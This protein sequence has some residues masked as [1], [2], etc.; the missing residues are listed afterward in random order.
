MKLKGG[1]DSNNM[2]SCCNENSKQIKKLIAINVPISKCN[3]RCH[4]CYLTQLNAWDKDEPKLEYSP[5]FIGKAFSKKRLGGTCLIN[6]TG[7]GETL[8]LPEMPEIIRVLLE[9][10]HFLEVVTNGLLTQRFEELAK[11]PEELLNRLELKCSFHYLELKKRNLMDVFFD[12]IAMIKSA[13]ASVTIEL[14]P[15]DEIIDEIEDIKRVCLERMGALCHLT[16]GR[17][18]TNARDV[19]TKLPLDEYKKTWSQFDSEMFNFK[20][21]VLNVKRKEFCYAGLWTLYVNLFTG[22]ARQCYGCRSNQ[23]IYKNIE[24]PIVFRPVGK[25]CKQP[26]C[27][28][29]HAFLTLGVIPELDTPS[30]LD[31]R[32]RID[33]SGKHWFSDA[34]IVAFSTRLSE[35]N[36][37]YTSVEKIKYYISAPIHGMRIIFANLKKGVAVICKR[38]RK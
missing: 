1:K 20:M 17:D 3:L 4:Y 24:K 15:N 8:I 10:G 38:R 19:L 25:G 33:E 21:D 29:A 9:E 6:L 31:M 2:S 34:G 16:V 28:N 7:K 5:E 23:N 30:Y 18:D 14:M 22:E 36:K 35:T 12:N 11:M 26:F 27:Y 32:D 13:G 37:P